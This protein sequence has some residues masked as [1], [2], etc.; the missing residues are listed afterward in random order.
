M[1]ECPP[2]GGTN[3]CTETFTPLIYCVI[4]HALL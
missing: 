4:D 3:T 1:L 2:V